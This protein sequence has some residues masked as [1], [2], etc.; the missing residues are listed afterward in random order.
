MKKPLLMLC[1]VAIAASGCK[2]LVKQLVDYQE[3]WPNGLPKSRGQLFGDQQSG[4]WTLSY[5]SGRPLAKG[6]YEND[7]QVG[8]WTFYYENG[9]EMRSG[10]YDQAGLR[11]GEWLY[12]YDDQTPQSRGSYVADF[13]D[14]PWTFYGEDGAVTMTGCYENGKQAGP[15]SFYYA[16]GRPKAEGLYY[17]GDRVGPWQVWTEQGISRIQDFGLKAGIQLVREM[18]PGTDTVRRLGV[19]KNGKQVG[20]WSSYHQNGKLRF[21][22]AL[23]DGVPSGVFEARDENGVVIAQGLLDQGAVVSGIAVVQGVS[24]E[25]PAGK[26]AMMPGDVDPW[27]SHRRAY[28]RGARSASCRRSSWARRRPQL[29]ATSAYTAV[30]IRKE[31]EQP[32]AAS[33]APVAET[34]V[35]A[36]RRAAAAHA[37]AGAAAA[38]RQAEEGAGPVRRRIHRRAP[39]RARAACSTTT[40]PARTARDRRAPAAA[41]TSRASRCP[42]RSCRASTA[43]TS[44]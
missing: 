12:K 3:Y 22:C 26:L 9:N 44:T 34:I 6:T 39:R 7:R 16:G 31:S 29:P 43:A 13:E 42:S 21:C 20:R 28:A 25:L 30:V 1:L 19:L 33:P 2:F 35:D 10:S 23:D 40:R 5:E 15:W 17:R 14:G 27:S 24:R 8:P 11:T 18:W 41:R 37:G 36:D 32:T 4:E 38:D